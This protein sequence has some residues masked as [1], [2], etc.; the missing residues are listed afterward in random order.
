[1]AIKVFNSMSRAKEDFA[2]LAPPRAHVYVC[3]VTVY[4]LCHIG[5]ARSA[6]AF[7]VIRRYLEFKRF[8]VTFVKNFTDVEDKI[9]KRAQAEDVPAL[10]ISERYIE[11]YRADMASIGVRPADV[12]PKAT[13]HVPEMI[14]LIERLIGNGTAYAV[15]GDVYFEVKR[16]PPYG[17]LSGKN[18]DELQ[19][20][21]RVDV[22]ERKRD[23]LDFALWKA[24]KPGEPAWARPWGPG[25]QRV[26]V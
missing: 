11:A 20:G 4:D 16:F 8:Q 19:A 24:A 6:I 17:R 22:D 12:E 21:A 5:H 1:M 10:E 2:P 3:G 25:R 23:A 26:L 9:I 13:D 15:D 7:D 14:A 18:L